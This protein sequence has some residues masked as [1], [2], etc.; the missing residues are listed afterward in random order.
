MRQLSVIRGPTPDT[1]D[2]MARSGP[3]LDPVLAF[4]TQSVFKST[5]KSQFTHKSVN[6]LF[7]LVILKDKLTD[8]RES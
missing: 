7:T 2:V 8:L 1:V 5:Y 6:L 3:A 4:L